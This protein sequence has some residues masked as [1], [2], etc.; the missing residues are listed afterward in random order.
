MIATKQPLFKAFLTPE[1]QQKLTGK[2]TS[3]K[4]SFN[5][6]IRSGTVNP[7]S[8]IG[9]YA[10]DEECYA[11]FEELLRPLIMR[12]HLCKEKRHCSSWKIQQRII[13]PDPEGKYIQSIRIR[14]ARNL[15][16]EKFPASMKLEE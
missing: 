3:L 14:I 10:G 7:D 15:H 6:L 12:Y 13:N 16:G 4:W 5:D 2:K 9:V 1:L 11:V 8:A